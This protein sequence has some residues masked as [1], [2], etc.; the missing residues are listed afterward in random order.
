MLTRV[1]DTWTG[2]YSTY[3]LEE[4][5]GKGGNAVVYRAVD[6]N[7][8]RVVAVKK[9]VAND[10]A[11]VRLWLREVET[12][13]SLN[14]DKN[15]Y[16]IHYLDHMRLD[17]TPSGT[18]FMLVEEYAVGGSL[19]K[20]VRPQGLPEK[21]AAAYMYRI[22][23]GLAFIHSKRV[24]HRDLKCA[25]VL[26]CE[27]DV[28]KL[29]D[30]GL[31]APCPVAAAADAEEMPQEEEGALLGSVYW[32]APE[33]ARGEL[34]APSSDV[35]S[36]GCL[37][38][39]ALTGR[40]PYFDR[41]P[42]N[43]LYHIADSEESPIPAAL[44]SNVSE[45][46]RV[47][48]NACL[49]RH[50][51][52][53]PAA[54]DL[55]KFKW[56]FDFRVQSKIAA[57]VSRQGEVR[58]GS[59]ARAAADNLRSSVM[60]ETS[61]GSSDDVGVWVEQCLFSG[62]AA[63]HEEWLQG[64][65]LGQVVSVLPDI[66]P[67]ESFSVIRIFSFAAERCR[68]EDSCFLE[69][70]GDT[71]LWQHK[72]LNELCRPDVL[73][74]L[75]SCCCDMQRPKDVRQY[76]PTCPEALCFVLQSTDEGAARLCVEALHRLLVPPTA[77][78]VPAREA[79]PQA[80]AGDVTLSPQEKNR[81]RSVADG[82]E[83][84]QLAQQR[85]LKDGGLIALRGVVE[86]LSRASLQSNVAPALGWPHVEKLFEIICAVEALPGAD[87]IVWGTLSPNVSGSGAAADGGASARGAELP[88][89]AMPAAPKGPRKE[90]QEARD[91]GAT[92]ELPKEPWHLAL[93][94][95]SRH[96]CPHAVELLLKMMRMPTSPELSSYLTKSGLIL[97]GTLLLVAIST[98][99]PR[100]LR[101]EALRTL[102]GLQRGSPRAAQ[103]LRD[104]KGSLPLLANIIKRLGGKPEGED[105]LK[106]IF[107]LC[108]DERT[109][110]AAA[111]SPIFCSAV[112]YSLVEFVDKSG[113]WELSK[114]LLELLFKHA[115]R[116]CEFLP[117][118]PA[119][120]A[121]GERSMVEVRQKLVNAGIIAQ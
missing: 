44:G 21:K 120:F 98:N 53:R 74:T 17:H 87:R 70:L 69:R 97:T 108:D 82:S 48:L 30:F 90:G 27:N 77:A 9:M 93:V 96:L 102:P 4:I 113:V 59:P 46:C 49:A 31:A 19:M 89:G 58:E 71:D 100:Q 5:V 1:S 111:Q 35:W 76:A 79:Q 95:G 40:P 104:P 12:L 16:V 54:A 56:F 60:R 99:V 51:E 57:L 86:Q 65:F 101:V 3:Q 110:T 39:E 10:E 20:L 112:Y 106:V 26:L 50:P 22:T 105:M 36:L 107:I 55:I 13:I 119:T 72:N 33:I 118:D 8:R 91:E 24:V 117:V 80:E 94:E 25:N 29:S 7:S 83:R 11:T 18:I 92:S 116:P 34:Q 45:E 103:F 38:V 81:R 14:E 2:R 6:Q 42:V 32:M 28:A 63:A 43:A 47:F 52:D 85:L 73:G 67:D 88:I 121:Q 64:P 68:K 115:S 37:C 109:V 23:C 114:K 41:T 66:T 15:E 84:R 62:A 75:F 61:E 78:A